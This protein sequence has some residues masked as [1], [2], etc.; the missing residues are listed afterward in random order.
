MARTTNR[1]I[2]CEYG[3]GNFT[4][5]EAQGTVNI[6]NRNYARKIVNQLQN[7]CPSWANEFYLEFTEPPGSDLHLNNLIIN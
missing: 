7:R 2:V 3:W 5:R 6:G 1:L 4:E